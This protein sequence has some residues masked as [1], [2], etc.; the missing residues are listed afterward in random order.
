MD[1]KGG[2]LFPVNNMETKGMSVCTLLGNSAL[3]PWLTKPYPDAR[4][5]DR[6]R[7]NYRQ[8][9]SRMVVEYLFG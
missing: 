8:S 9:D 3:L 4:A 2:T 7:F 6:R 1:K 5:P